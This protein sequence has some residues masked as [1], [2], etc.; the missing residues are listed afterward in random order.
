MKTGFGSEF[1]AAVTKRFRPLAL[2]DA[3]P[4]R[5]AAGEL[6]LVFCYLLA[7]CWAQYFTLKI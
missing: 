5:W 4:S 6:L 3:M 2:Q 7:P 1:F